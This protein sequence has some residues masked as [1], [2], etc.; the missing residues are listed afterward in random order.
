MIY[1]K[2]LCET[3]FHILSLYTGPRDYSSAKRHKVTFS[4]TALTD[5]DAPSSFAQSSPLSIVITNDN[6]I[7]ST[8]YFQVRIVE[9]SITSFG[10]RIGQRSMANVTI[11]DDDSKWHPCTHKCLIIILIIILIPIF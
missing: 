1:L 11:L 8:E 10:A 4:Q 2:I 3:V 6:Q 9:T 5:R 7:E